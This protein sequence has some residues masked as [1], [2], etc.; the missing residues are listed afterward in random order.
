MSVW[1]GVTVMD[2]EEGVVVN[3]ASYGGKALTTDAK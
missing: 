1:A 3:E 2:G